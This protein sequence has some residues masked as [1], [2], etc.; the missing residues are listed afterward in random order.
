MLL[1]RS[2][3]NLKLQD[4]K[5]LNKMIIKAMKLSEKAHEG[6]KDKA[7]ED[8]FLHPLTVAFTLSNNGYGDEYI[9]TG[10]LHDII[11]DTSYT[12]DDLI[13]E[14]FSS[15]VIK[16]LK[17]L[18][19]QKEI[20][21]TDYIKEIKKNPIARAVKIADLLHNSDASRLTQLSASDKMRMEKYRMATEYLNAE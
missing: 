21:Y 3:K 8:Y 2:R 11:E 13:K 16:A 19:H 9:I 10:L 15:E 12:S 17:L 14:G 20:P 7:G 5:R 1:L 6:Q 18:T 4:M